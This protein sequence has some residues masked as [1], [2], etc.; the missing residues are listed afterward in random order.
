MDEDTR[1]MVAEAERMDDA[2]RRR[3]EDF[4]VRLAQLQRAA[5]REVLYR[6]QENALVQPQQENNAV[7]KQDVLSLVDALADEIG[8]AT[9]RLE[10]RINELNEKILKL[11][12][13]NEVLRSFVTTKVATLTS[14]KGKADVA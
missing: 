13:T 10:K 5:P 1:W 3:N 6:T 11:E 7:S 8:G 4:E 9:G 12:I 14:I 2:A